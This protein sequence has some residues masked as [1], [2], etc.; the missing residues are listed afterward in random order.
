MF[1]TLI[2]TCFKPPITLHI[3]YLEY[4]LYKINSLFLIKHFILMKNIKCFI[5]L[6][7]CLEQGFTDLYTVQTGNIAITLICR[8]AVFKSCYLFNAVVFLLVFD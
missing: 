1:H 7:Q 3:H 8:I 5:K 6:T 2:K 4:V